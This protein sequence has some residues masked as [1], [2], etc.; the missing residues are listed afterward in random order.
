[1][2]AC[3]SSA[4]KAPLKQVEASREHARQNVSQ[5]AEAWQ[6]ANG[7][8]LYHLVVRDDP[9][10]SADCPQGDGWAEAALMDKTTQQTVRLLK[11][12]TVSASLGCMT[13]ATFDG[14]AHRREEDVCNTA[15]PAPLP[16]L[17]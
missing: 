7:F 3:R 2:A 4:G 8:E 6:K 5:L 16:R 17:Q 11:C 14:T 1:M 12:S 10:I 15:L 13:S 9:T